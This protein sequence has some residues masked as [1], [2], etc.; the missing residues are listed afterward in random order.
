LECQSADFVKNLLQSSNF[1]ENMNLEVPYCLELKN[2]FIS[3][4]YDAILK[5][6]MAYHFAM[7]N[8]MTELCEYQSLNS[9][10]LQSPRTPKTNQRV[11]IS[12]HSKPSSNSSVLG[13]V[14]NKQL[15][16]SIISP[17]TMAQMVPNPDSKHKRRSDSNSFGSSP[18]AMSL[19]KF[20]GRQ[21]S[22][23]S[24]ELP[25]IDS[26]TSITFNPKVMFRTHHDKDALLNT[27]L[28]AAGTY[29]KLRRYQQPCSPLSYL[30]K[31][32]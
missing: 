15:S 23:I 32:V 22:G 20:H 28:H 31:V 29:L 7:L 12:S 27:I 17:G 19:A 2:S 26:A 8:Q 16:P 21:I 18:Y 4:V 13:T 1:L 30:L 5:T 3:K 6:D 9:G 24:E 14:G 25:S 10:I 11:S